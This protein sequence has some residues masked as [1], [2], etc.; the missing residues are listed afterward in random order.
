MPPSPHIYDHE[1]TL[2]TKNGHVPSASTQMRS[3]AAVVTDFQCLLNGGQGGDQE[4][5]TLCSGRT[6]LWI[7]RCSLEIVRAQCLHLLI[8]RKALK[9]LKG[10]SAP[11][12]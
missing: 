2:P 11:H 9:S 8:P 3:L 4:W 7:V 6:G 5:D 10:T 1:G 12:D